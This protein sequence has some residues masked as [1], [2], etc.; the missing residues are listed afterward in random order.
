MY[1]IGCCVWRQSGGCEFASVIGKLHPKDAL[2]PRP[3]LCSEC[4]M[5]A[6]LRGVC[7]VR[8]V[9]CLRQMALRAC[10]SRK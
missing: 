3:L 10:I 4:L 5:S 2:L 9:R 6:F 1:E 8:V 7:F